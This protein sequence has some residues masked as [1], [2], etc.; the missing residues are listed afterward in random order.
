MEQDPRFFEPGTLVEVTDVTIQNRFLLRP[1]DELNDVVVGVLGRAQ[2]L[3]DMPVVAAVALSTHLHLLL[4]PRDPEHLADFMCH[5]KTNISKE[6]G[7]LHDWPGKL[8]KGP[9]KMVLVSG[10]E[11]AQVRRLEYL[12]SNS[13]KEFLVDRV[14]QWPGVHSAEALVE[15]TPL[16]GTWYDRTQEHHAR[17][18]NEDFDPEDFATQER[19]VFSPL[20][21]WAHLPSEE[22]RGRVAEIV[23]RVDEAAA[24]ER[25]RTGSRSLGVK[26]ILRT[27]PHKRPR[28][29]ERSPQP[30]FHAATK[31]VLQQMRE[32]HAEVVAA[33]REASQKLLA[34]D[35]D[36]AFPEGTFPPGLPFIPFAGGARGQPA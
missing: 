7:H 33:F 2:S 6:V 9:Y 24:R 27:S 5:I 18:R 10:E 23:A 15:G 1:S 3:Y 13:V 26:K 14:G 19:L 25:Q 31:R 29:V 22:Y 32:A 17:Q 35:R 34:G 30:R 28:R 4:E 20:P 8:W 16:T 12:I 36:A 11:R 21:C